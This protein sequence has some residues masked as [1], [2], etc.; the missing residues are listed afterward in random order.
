[1]SRNLYYDLFRYLYDHYDIS[2]GTAL[3]KFAKSKVRTHQNLID[4]IHIK[5]MLNE[6]ENRGIITWKA[7]KITTNQDGVTSYHWLDIP[8]YKNDLG[9][10]NNHTFENT[11]VEA[12]LTPD[13]GLDYASNIIN[14]LTGISINKW[15]KGLTF[16]L[17]IV[18]IIAAF[19]Q[20]LQYRQSV[21][22]SE[23]S[24]KKHTLSNK[25]Y[26]TGYCPHQ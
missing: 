11:R 22:K 18:A 23:V 12:H 10:D 26:Q 17:L 21:G 5:N 9:K 14:T 25:D 8:K 7:D 13:K 1:M 6:L 2:G 20:F 19:L 24:C 3:D 16:G 4:I 15:I